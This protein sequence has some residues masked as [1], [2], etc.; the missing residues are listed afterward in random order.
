MIWEPRKCDH[1][2]R[3]YDRGAAPAVSDV[4]AAVKVLVLDYSRLVLP[5]ASPF[6][7]KQNILDLC[8][9]QLQKIV[10]AHTLDSGH[11]RWLHKL[12]Q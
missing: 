2:S 3:K 10:I 8:C 4:A 12:E 1:M 9:Q 11:K 7:S 5:H 6:G